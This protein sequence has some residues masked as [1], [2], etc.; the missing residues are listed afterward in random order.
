MTNEIV[1]FQNQNVKLNVNMKDE[2][3]WLNREQMAELFGR[4]AKTIDKHIKNA[5]EEELDNSTV[6]KFATVQKEG[7]REIKREIKY[8]SLDMIISVGYRVKSK[9]GVIFRKWAN[10]VLKD[11]L[12]K[13][14]A[15]NDARLKALEKTVQLLDVATRANDRLDSGDG[16]REILKVLGSYTKALDLLDSYDH[17]SLPKV[18]G[19]KSDKMIKAE[20]CETIIKGLRYSETS[21]IFGVE[22][23]GFSLESII[24]NIY[25]SFAGEDVYSTVEEKIAN[26]LYL[27]V[28]NHVFVDGNK[29]IAATLFIYAL[30]FYGLLYQNG[31]R[32]ID[33]NSLTAL[34]LLIAESNPQEK[35]LMIELVENF[36]G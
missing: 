26:L 2:T 22:R 14:Y 17:K 8:Y 32:I 19:T 5:L 29:R 27:V 12:I 6:A 21:D 30:D 31:S 1:I 9:N 24:L 16:A 36:I 33:N 28:K 7:K 15:V 35:S 25:Q 20:D 10:K 13:G 3:V 11:Y 34:T 23:E 4:D 18:E